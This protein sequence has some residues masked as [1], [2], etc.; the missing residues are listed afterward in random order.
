MNLLRLSFSYI[1]RRKLNT[2][3][4][5]LILALGIA[6]IV[7][8]LLFKQQ[9]EENLTRNAE[10]IDAVV[11]A[12]GSPLQ[13]ILSSIYHLDVPTGNIPVKEASK[14]IKSRAVKNAI[15]LSLGDSYRGFRIVGTVPAYLDLYRAEFQEGKI[16]SHSLEVVVG[17]EAAIA[18][19]I[20][21]GDNLVSTH[22]F[23]EAGDAHGDHGMSVVGI[24]K[25]TGTVLD[26]LVVS[27][28]HT[29]WD[30]HAKGGHE[31]SHEH[32]SVAAVKGPFRFSP[33]DSAQQVTSLLIQY[34]SPMAAVM[35][36]RFVNGTTTLQAAA[37][38][39]ETARLF[40]LL[41]VGVNALRAFGAILMLVA[42]LG[43]FIALY[44]ALKERRYDLAMMRTL[45]ASSGKLLTHVLLE[46]LLLTGMGIIV[47]LGIGHLA[48]EFL[49]N[50]FA[51]AR[52]MDLTGWRWL[53]EEWLVIAVALGIGI[54]AAIIPALQAYRTDIAQTLQ[55]K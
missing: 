13:L 52:Q 18:Q 8:L 49:G 19:K 27:D 33:E 35:F 48:A 51:E 45:G 16:W 21:L 14:L 47:G 46:G 26:R 15:P 24:L 7:V 28:L 31:E 10:G 17:S 32:E 3:L 12:K 54:V 44:N 36:P 42:A 25:P 41:G 23:D 22:G 29:I 40:S 38:A 6:T 11:G 1:R 30:M 2:F 55:R 9:F 43:I 53:S 37:P 34:S 20:S 50:S 4:N 5:V 39:I